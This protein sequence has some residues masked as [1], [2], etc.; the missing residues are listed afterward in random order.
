MSLAIKEI[1]DPI[2]IGLENK[3]DLDLLVKIGG[4]SGSVGILGYKGIETSKLFW[5]CEC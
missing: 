1:L 2:E 5:I 4:I 3:A